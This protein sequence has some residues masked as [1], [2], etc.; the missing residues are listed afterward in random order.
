MDFKA[1]VVLNEAQLAE[2]VHEETD[3][4][5]GGADHLGQ[6]FLTDL[7]NHLLWRA[8]LAEVGEQEQYSRQPF[9]ARVEKPVDEIFFDPDV[10]G[11]LVR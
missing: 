9:L 1:A 6:G 2:L 3:S 5:P 10:T 8:V 11:E 7:R 4:G